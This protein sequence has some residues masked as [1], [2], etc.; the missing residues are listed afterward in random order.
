MWDGVIID[1]LENNSKYT[2]LF[3]E[4]LMY[5]IECGNKIEDDAKFCSKCGRKVTRNQDDIGSNFSIE[6]QPQYTAISNSNIEN[7]SFC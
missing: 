3:N 7:N 6:L 2:F 4:V 5:C 1:S